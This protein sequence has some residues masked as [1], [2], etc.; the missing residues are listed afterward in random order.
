MMLEPVPVNRYLVDRH[1]HLFTLLSTLS[2]LFSNKFYSVVIYIRLALKL[3][4]CNCEC[5]DRHGLNL[6]SPPGSGKKIKDPQTNQIGQFNFSSTSRP[7]TSLCF[8][9][10]TE[11]R[12]VIARLL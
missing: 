7:I 6:K 2:N 3:Q 11:Y 4:N 1:P 10:V 12:S 9:H 5:Q 8:T